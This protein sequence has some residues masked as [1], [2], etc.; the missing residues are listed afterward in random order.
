MGYGTFVLYPAVRK[1]AEQAVTVR[2]WI[3]EGWDC[4]FHSLFMAHA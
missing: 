1:L 2:S 3:A 4:P